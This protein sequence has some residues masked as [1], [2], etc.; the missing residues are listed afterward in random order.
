MSFRS[1]LFSRLEF[2]H[3]TPLEQHPAV[4]KEN[5]CRWTFR[6]LA[7]EQVNGARLQ[8]RAAGK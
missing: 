6:P 3:T 7:I 8:P 4:H 2:V 5:V 1:P